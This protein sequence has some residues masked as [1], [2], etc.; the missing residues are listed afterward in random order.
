MRAQGEE[1]GTLDEYVDD[2]Q[3][4]GPSGGLLVGHELRYLCNLMAG[5]KD[6]IIV[7]IT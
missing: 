2:K 1:Q 4:G 6:P 3:I 5:T 7:F